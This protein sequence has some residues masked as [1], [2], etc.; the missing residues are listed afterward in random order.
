MK[1]MNVALKEKYGL[2]INGQW[3]DASDGATFAT[4]NPATGEHLAYCAEATKEDVDDAEDNLQKFCDEN[5][6]VASEISESLQMETA[7]YIRH[8][9]HSMEY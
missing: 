9:K 5:R 7:V 4:K 6:D 3:R 8:L 2:Y 1:V